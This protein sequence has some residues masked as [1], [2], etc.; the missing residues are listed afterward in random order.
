MQPFGVDRVER[1]FH[2]LEPVAGHDRAAEH[3]DRAFGDEAVEA[4]Q[5]RLG[6]GGTEIG[7]DHA[8]QFLDG[9]GGRA[10]L[11][12]ER[13]FLR[14]VRLREAFAVPGKLP[15]VIGAADAVL[16]RDAIGERGAAVRAP[17]GDQAEPALAVLEQHE[18]FAEH[19]DALVPD[20]AFELGCRCDRVPVAAHQVA[21]RGARPDAGEQFVLL[22]RQHRRLF[23]DGMIPK[24]VSGFRINLPGAK[25]VYSL[26][27][28][29]TSEGL[30]NQW[31]R[32]FASGLQGW[33]QRDARSC[34]RS[35]GTAAFELAAVAEPVAEVREEIARE[36]GAKGFA[37]L[38]S[39]LA[40]AA[41]DA[42]YIATPTELHPE[43]AALAFAA[44]QAR[45]DRKADGD[46][47]RSGPD[48]DRGCRTRGRR[49]AGRPLAF[50]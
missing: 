3:A 21:G 40:G 13:A 26:P 5:Q 9:I 34:L 7:P 11:V 4:R 50:L 10:D 43:H 42:I 31:R 8:A 15:A 32:R 37:D 45:A 49:A 35:A 16:G 22:R 44:K 38:P 19:A 33:A 2:D 17:L 23:T 18:V 1:V 47:A 41:L 12:A 36:T 29:E 14:L 30:Q 28:A 25:T 27:A 20:L 46:H 39:M 48:H 24:M 6:F